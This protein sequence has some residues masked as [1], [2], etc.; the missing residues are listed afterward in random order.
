MIIRGSWGIFSQV[1]LVERKDSLAD[2][3]VVEDTA[4]A[5]P[6][7]EVQGMGSIDGVTG[8]QVRS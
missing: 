3:L 1:G 2:K 8:I 6:V 5:D 4:S 7:F